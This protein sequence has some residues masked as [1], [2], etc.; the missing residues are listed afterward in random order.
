MDCEIITFCFYVL[1]AIFAVI[2]SI[3]W[4]KKG[5]NR[6]HPPSMRYFKYRVDMKME[7]NAK[8][9]NGQ[10]LMGI[11]QSD[12]RLVFNQ[13][14]FFGLFLPNIFQLPNLRRIRWRTEHF[15]GK[16]RET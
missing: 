2:A 11:I 8:Q 3:F 6:K 16:R 15:R 5:L 12:L 10:T 9:S 14:L 7:L 13:T 4:R 1:L